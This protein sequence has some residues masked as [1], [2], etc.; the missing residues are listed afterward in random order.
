MVASRPATERLVVGRSGGQL[1]SA[2]DRPN[3]KP[4]EMGS[5]H[6]AVVKLIGSNEGY[7]IQTCTSSL[8]T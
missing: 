7:K 3:G 2:S 4:I 8:P 6:D 5:S 1:G